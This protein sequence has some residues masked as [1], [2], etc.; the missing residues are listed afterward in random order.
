MPVVA[1]RRKAAILFSAAAVIA[2]CV[3]AVLVV[4]LAKTNR[5]NN[6]GQ[7]SSIRAS[8]DS[9]SSDV[10]SQARKQQQDSSQSVSIS[11]SD[12][13]GSISD[14]SRLTSAE[15]I[16]IPAPAPSMVQQ[17]AAPTPAPSKA[18][19][20]GSDYPSI[21]PA[22]WGT[23]SPT[24]RWQQLVTE[25][26]RH[27]AIK[28]QRQRRLRESYHEEL[29]KKRLTTAAM[30]TLDNNNKQVEDNNNNNKKA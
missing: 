9:Q 17:L 19:T 12:D 4:P 8:S 30:T 2:L 14:R 27:H 1:L 24:A 10:F 7:P 20:L 6:I 3:G 22:T 15:N 25:K 16:S 23:A 11:S 28:V 26:G 13:G 29:R 18:P 5:I 21:V